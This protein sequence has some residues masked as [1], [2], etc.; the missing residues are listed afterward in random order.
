MPALDAHVV[1]HV[2]RM[3]GNGREW[4]AMEG[5]GREWKAME[6]NGRHVVLPTYLSSY[7]IEEEEVLPR[8]CSTEREGAMS[9]GSSLRA[10]R[11]GYRS[12]K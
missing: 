11:A 6:G 9:V 2:P 12:R 3:E 5:D 4:K 8:V 10:T 1:L 7:Q